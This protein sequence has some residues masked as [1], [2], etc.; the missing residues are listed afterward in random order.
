MVQCSSKIK[1]IVIEGALRFTVVYLYACQ[2]KTVHIEIFSNM[3]TEAF[4]VAL[5]RFVG[6]RGNPA[7]I[8]SDKA[9]TFVGAK[10][11]GRESYVLI[12]S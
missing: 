12:E 10:N 6:R 9:N 5:L 3:T 11:E 8:F 2:H 1:N 4:I 7:L